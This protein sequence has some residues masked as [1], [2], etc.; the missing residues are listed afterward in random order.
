MLQQMNHAPAE[1]RNVPQIGL[2]DRLAG[3]LLDWAVTCMERRPSVWFSRSNAQGSDADWPPP[4][5]PQ[6]IVRA[7]QDIRL[8][9]LVSYVAEKSPFYSSAFARMNFDARRF[10]G[11]AGIS[12]LP[13][14]TPEDVQRGEQLRCVPYE[15]VA[16]VFTTSGTSR[17][18]KEI[19]LTKGDFDGMVNL[20][21][22][23]QRGQLSSR[24]VMMV[25]HAEGMFCILPFAQAVTE[26]LGGLV[27]P[28]GQPTPTETLKLIDRFRPNAFMTS[29]SYMAAVTKAAAAESFTYKLERVDLDGEIMTP[30]QGKHIAEYWGA[31]VYN[32]YGMTEVGSIGFGAPGCDAVHLN[33]LQTHVEILDP[34]TLEPAEEGE[35]VATTLT[36][37]AMPL[38]RYRTGDRCRWVNCRCGWLAP[39]IRVAGRIGDDV[40]IAATNLHGVRIAESLSELDGV[41]GSVE[42]VVDHIDGVD[43]LSLRVGVEPEH[44]LRPDA[45]VQ[46]LFAAYPALREDHR[47]SAFE[48]SVELAE[49]LR[50][51]PK[52]LRVRD[53][54]A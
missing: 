17:E 8:R 43:Q 47:A 21:V 44:R 1:V 19:W 16:R 14:T 54:R 50:L 53:L 23:M 6:A 33:D 13:L 42:V 10:E 20:A 31:E 7:V 48:M 18:P 25:A 29:P 51:A 5:I 32:G 35:L 15:E 24:R 39:A 40:V 30:R 26:R 34:L 36:F 4:V 11:I 45:V 46:R 38:L 9:R 12:G 49:N 27:L 3:R 52:S 28:I 22:N 41:T 37:R 2:R